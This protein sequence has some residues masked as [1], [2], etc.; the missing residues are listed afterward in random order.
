MRKIIVPRQKGVSLNLLPANY[1]SSKVKMTQA[2]YTKK[3]T[4]GQS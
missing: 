4:D 2:H 3:L 1:K